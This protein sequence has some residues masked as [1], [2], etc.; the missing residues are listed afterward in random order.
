MAGD[1]RDRVRVGQ[2]LPMRRRGLPQVVDG[3]R[4]RE[5]GWFADIGEPQADAACKA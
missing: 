3:P 1:G 4:V 2:P 5:P